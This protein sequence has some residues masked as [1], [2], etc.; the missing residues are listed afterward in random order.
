M[1]QEPRNNLIALP[2]KALRKRSR[3][4]GLIDSTITK[5]IKDMQAAV[6]DW[7]DHREHEVGV[8]LSAVQINKLYRIIILRKAPD[9][10]NNREFNVFIN[11][12]ITKATGKVSEDFEG[13]LSV[14]DIYGKVPRYEKIKLKALD[15]NGAEVKIT[16]EGFL[17]RV[18]QHEIDHIN[19]KLFIDHIKNNPKAFYKLESDGKLI[20]I[21]YDKQI[22]N[23]SILW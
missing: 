9:D 20:E 16:L 22:K 17:A 5:I 8:A 2:S 7:E 23:S 19:G 12:E 6:L 1:K 3:R 13:C 21:D 10:K 15:E 11:P 18:I 14:K 4:V